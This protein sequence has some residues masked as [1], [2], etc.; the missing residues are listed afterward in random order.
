[1]EDDALAVVLDMGS[2]FFKAGMA[3]DDAPRIVF[4][5]IVGL[6]KHEG[7][8]VGMGEKDFY[9]GD[10]AQAKRG[11]LNLRYPVER[12]E[13]KDWEDIDRVI[14][15]TY[16]NELRLQPEEHPVIITESVKMT[17]ESREKAIQLMFEKF[18][19]SGF[20]LL[21]KPILSLYASGR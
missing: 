11:I 20:H 19:V 2:G 10:E 14:H 15:H 21:P 18:N 5:H 6:P 7:V 1:M 13:V 9:I 3:G 16:Y 12:G 17:N 4:P 8:A